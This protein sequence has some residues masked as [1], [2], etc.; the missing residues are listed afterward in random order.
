MH[1]ASNQLT[2]AKACFASVLQAA[3]RAREGNVRVEERADD[4]VIFYSTTYSAA[5]AAAACAAALA[6]FSAITSF[7][8]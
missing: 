7:A 8:G 6:A 5:L 3:S 1:D 2:Q 4:D